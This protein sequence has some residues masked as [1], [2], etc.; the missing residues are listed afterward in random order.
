M[1]WRAVQLF[2]GKALLLARYLILAR[3]LDPDEFGLFAIAVVPLDVLLSATN[4]G[5]I[6]AL[7]QRRQSETRQYDAAWTVGLA[8][9]LAI[10][11]VVFVAAPLLAGFFSEPRAAPLLRGLAL[12]P[13]LG[14]LASIRVADLERDLRFRSLAVLELS[15]TLVA[16]AVSI[17]LASAVGAWAL[18]AGT[19]VGS[20]AGTLLSYVLAPHRPRL[21]LDPGSAGPLFRYG[22]W[23]LL[24]GLIEVVGDAV[25]RAVISRQLGT[26][27]VGLYFLAASLALLPNDVVS[28]I[29]GA[30][31]FPVHAQ[32]Q[33]DPRRVGLA[34]RASF[35]AMAAVL[36]PVYAIVAALAPSLVRYVL[37]PQWTGTEPVIRVLAIAGILG[38]LFDA[39]SPLLQGRGQP[40]KLAALFTVLTTSVV[41]S[42]WALTRAYGLMGAAMAWV[43]AQAVVCAVCAIYARQALGHSP[44]HGLVKPLTAI[45]VASGMAGMIAWS[46]D[47]VLPGILGLGTAVA[48]ASV[49]TA[50]LLWALDGQLGLGLLRDFAHAF[51]RLAERLRLPL[52]NA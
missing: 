23:I 48:A 37:S 26:A 7:V 33:S 12:R 13:V 4:F 32:V 9:A 20:L 11:A 50:T 46:I 1:V 22:R 15:S 28:G 30:V 42:V 2:G 34:F 40:Q 10:G 18:I 47:A 36:M 3:L 44:F 52:A 51:P 29:V 39:T 27:S 14:A 45:A 41:T 21:A 8:R 19:L 24:S 43:L 17:A 16:A 49:V 6:P 38:I 31:A 25:L 5:M 35:V